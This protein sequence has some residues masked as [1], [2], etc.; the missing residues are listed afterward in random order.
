MDVLTLLYETTFHELDFSPPVLKQNEEEMEQ[1]QRL[2]RK[3]LRKKNEPVPRNPIPSLP[4]YSM[5]GHGCDTGNIMRVPKNCVYV[6]LSICGDTMTMDSV[7]QETFYTLFRDSDKMLQ[8]PL[9]YKKELSKVGMNVHIH[10]DGQ[11]ADGTWC[12]PT[13]MDCSYHPFLHYQVDNTVSAS[14]LH[15]MGDDLFMK[16]HPSVEITKSPYT[17]LQFVTWPPVATPETLDVIYGNSL[18]PTVEE[19]KSSIT[20]VYTAAKVSAVAKRIKQSELFKTRPGIYYNIVCRDPCRGAFPIKIRMRRQHSERQD[21]SPMKIPD[22]TPLSFDAL[23]NALDIYLKSPTEFAPI[24]TWN[25]S[26]VIHLNELF[27]PEFNEDITSWDVS[28]IHLMEDTFKNTQ[29]NRSLASWNPLS[30]VIFGAANS[31]IP[32]LFDLPPTLK[33]LDITNCP[34]HH[35]NF[36]TLHP[37]F[38]IKCKGVPLDSDTVTRLITFYTSD[39]KVSTEEKLEMLDQFRRGAMKRTKKSC[40]QRFRSKK[41]QNLLTDSWK[42]YYDHL[43]KTKRY[44]PKHEYKRFASEFKKGYMDS[45]KTR[46]NKR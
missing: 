23:H 22:F 20:G 8:D 3:F 7:I 1:L 6:T 2:Y 35:L 9:R 27:P 15:Q 32:E 21:L 45:C 5:L 12:D 36:S 39:S 28:K 18:L 13:Y 4:V 24:G 29:F 31:K 34:I 16:G 17:S 14:G 40:I 26:H 25:V 38:K 43:M 41:V 37:K 11:F 30:L 19:L 44:I 46:K 33:L 10:Y 42:G